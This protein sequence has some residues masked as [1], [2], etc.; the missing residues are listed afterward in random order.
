MNHTKETLTSPK[1]EEL[2]REE[3]ERI[4]E[5]VIDLATN[6]RFN[7]DPNEYPIFSQQAGMRLNES[8]HRMEMT[9]LSI[10]ETLGRMVGATANT[11]SVINGEG[12]FPKADH[13]IYL[14]KSARP[15]SWLVDEFWDDFSDNPE[16][17]KSFLAIDRRPW[18]ERLGFELTGHEEIRNKNGELRPATGKDFWE[19]YDELPLEKQ[20]EWSARI[21]ALYIEGGID[22]ED[23]EKIMSTPTVLDGKNLLIIDEVS[24]SGSTLNIAKG[25]LKR[26][27]P[28]LTSVKGYIFW[29]DTSV[30]TE[31]GTQMGATPVWYPHD[32]SDWRGRGVK[33]I[34]IDYYKEQYQKNPS[35]D[36]L[37]RYYGAF[38]LGVPLVDKNE[39]PGQLSWKLRD[40]IKKMHTNY[41][42]GRILPNLPMGKDYTNDDS[43]ALE[44][45]MSHLEEKGV[46][47]VPASRAVGNPNAY[48]TLMKERNKKPR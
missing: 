5:K 48:L 30:E 13:V 4:G 23:P 32:P 47:F 40:E 35:K 14:D 31:A 45:T 29:K 2:S 11:I 6:S 15:V 34:D 38:V 17:S 24:R 19:K 33:D 18:F 37:A 42:D 28:E 20:L 9:T 12:G 8:T 21:R 27:I 39:E 22:S 46:E 36:T 7:V 26:A 25:L 10:N 1:P 16:P 3:K 41:E 43:V 44:K